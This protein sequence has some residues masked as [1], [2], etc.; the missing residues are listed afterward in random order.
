MEPTTSPVRAYGLSQLQTLR[1][2]RKLTQQQLSDVSGVKLS[3]IQ[4][5]E[6]GVVEDAVVSVAAPIAE[7]LAVPV[8]ALW[9]ASI[10][11]KLLEQEG[12]A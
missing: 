8:E 2:W 1:A 12:A 7:A 10:T 6:R 9:D 11:K 5:Q 3:T 4:K